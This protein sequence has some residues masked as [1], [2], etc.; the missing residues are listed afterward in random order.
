MAYIYPAKASA[1]ALQAIV[2]AANGYPKA[3]VD[4]PG[5][6]HVPGPFVTLTYA[7]VIQHPTL[8]LWSYLADGVTAPLVL[9]QPGL[10]L[11]TSLDATWNGGAAILPGG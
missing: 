7:A 3:G 1:Q 6:R 5:G 8:S 4:V 9:G 10:P 11:A 2:D